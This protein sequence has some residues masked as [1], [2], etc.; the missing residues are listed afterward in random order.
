LPTYPFQKIRTIVLD[1]KTIKL[2]LVGLSHFSL[3]SLTINH[4]LFQWDTAGQERYR[5]ITSSYYRGSHGIILVYD[6]TREETFSSI[7]QWLEELE[8]YASP[9]VN[10]LLIGNKSDLTSQ[11]AVDSS[12]VKVGSF[13]V[14]SLLYQLTAASSGIRRPEGDDLHRDLSQGVHQRRP[15]LLHH[16]CRH[17]EARV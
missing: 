8:R 15:G 13:A 5:T 14:G 4:T 17:Q 10:K 6:T 9:N 11:N 7:P 3:S 2:Q 1:G 12:Y 16:D